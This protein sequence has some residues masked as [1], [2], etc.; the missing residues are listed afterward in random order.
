MPV[1][2]CSASRQQLIAILI[3]STASLLFFY[4]ISGTFDNNW[5]F[6]D[7]PNLKGLESITDIESAYRFVTSGISSPIGRPISLASFLLNLSDWLDNEPAGFRVISSALHCI[8]SLLIYLFVLNLCRVI[9]SLEDKKYLLAAIVSVVWLFLP[10]NFS[11][12]LLPVQRMTILAGT[13]TLLGLLSFVLLRRKLITS[14]NLKWHVTLVFV[15]AGFSVLG[16][17]SKETGLLLPLYCFVLEKAVFKD[18]QPIVAYRWQW[19]ITKLALYWVPIS[20]VAGYFLLNLTNFIEGYSNRSFSFSE[21]V[22]TEI[23]ILLEYM[24]QIFAPQ[25]TRFGPFHDD[26]YTY[27]LFS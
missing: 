19:Y 21:R 25:L 20:A 24:K 7:W 27:S 17:L 10:L 6:D 5:F 16:L 11:A 1:S 23:V 14:S 22:A 18:K 13:F 9:E 12:I 8:N 15:I 26:H 3:V 4:L 2:F